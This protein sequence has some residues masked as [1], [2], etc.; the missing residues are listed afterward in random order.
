MWWH[1]PL[2]LRQR[3][4]GALPPALP[5][6][7]DELEPSPEAERESRGGRTARQGKLMVPREKPGLEVRRLRAD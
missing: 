3:R 2:F 6:V 1:G 5:P 4:A 7:G